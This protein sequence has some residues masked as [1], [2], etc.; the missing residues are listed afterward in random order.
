MRMKNPE[1]SKVE[2]F[3]NRQ[4]EYTDNIITTSSDKRTTIFAEVE[5]STVD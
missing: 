5:L 2:Y 1:F 3:G 4:A